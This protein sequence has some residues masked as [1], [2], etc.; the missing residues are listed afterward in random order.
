MFL[1][2]CKLDTKFDLN[3]LEHIVMKKV[4]C[5]IHASIM[6]DSRGGVEKER[7]HGGDRGLIPDR[8]R[9]ES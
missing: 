8:D 7:L 2:F 6:L 1:L 3:F 9:P 5:L 4:N